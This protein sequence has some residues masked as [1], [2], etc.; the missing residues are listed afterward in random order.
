MSRVSGG[1]AL[2][3]SVIGMNTRWQPCSSAITKALLT[4]SPSDLSVSQFDPSETL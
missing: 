4:N 3:A 2:G 1:P